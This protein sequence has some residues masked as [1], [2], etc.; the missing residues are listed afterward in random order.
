M[1]IRLKLILPAAAAFVIFAIILDAYWAPKLYNYAKE[2]FLEQMHS[3]LDAVKIDLIRHLL[4][5]D[6][7]ALY[8]SLEYQ[9]THHKNVWMNLRLYDHDHR[10]IFP[11]TDAP[12]DPLTDEGEPNRLQIPI[13]HDLVYNHRNIGEIHLLLD[14]TAHFKKR[15]QR[16]RELEQYLVLLLLGLFIVEY[17]WLNRQIRKP[18]ADLDKATE[19]LSQGDFTA[20]L[21]KFSRDELGRLSHHFDIMRKNLLSAQDKLKKKTGEAMA[22]SQA[23]SDFVAVMSHEIRTPMNGIVGMTQLLKETR[24]DDD[25]TEITELMDSACQSLL[26]IV[27]NILDISKVESGKMP[28]NPIEFNLEYLLHNAVKQVLLKADEKRVEVIMDYE[29]T[30]PK[31]LKG[32][33]GKIRQICLN[34]LSNAVKFTEQ[35]H[36]LLKVRCVKEQGGQKETKEQVDLTITVADTGVGIPQEQ[37]H[38]VFDAF[39]QADASS[40]RAYGGTGLG[41]AISKQLAKLMN[42]T[43][44]MESEPGKGTGFHFNLTLPKC[45]PP[46]DP[47]R[48]PIDAAGKRLLL[49]DAAPIDLDTLTVQLARLDADIVTLS[50][51]DLDIS[52]IL[53]Q[54]FHDCLFDLIIINGHMNFNDARQKI[55][56]IRQNQYSKNIPIMMLTPSAQRGDAEQLHQAG[57][58]AFLVKPVLPTL[59]HRAVCETLSRPIES[60]KSPLITAHTIREADQ[61]MTLS[62]TPLKL[63]GRLLLVEDNLVNQKVITKML[64]QTDLTVQVAKNGQV[65]VEMFCEQAFDLVLMDYQ[66]PVMDGIQATLKI[67]EFEHDNHRTK[68]PIMALTANVQPDVVQACYN[69]GMDAFIS[70]PVRFQVLTEK[71]KIFLNHF[72][73]T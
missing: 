62:D 73:A 46:P 66:M 63:S 55:N 72:E 27:N 21:P 68:T 31:A 19:K 38:S 42:G 11:L 56:T 70:K 22:A 10:Q 17:F 49:V 61:Q 6:F 23:K 4:A 69:A 26:S 20:P 5:N 8:A 28:L 34:L 16:I 24:L 33:A 57:I 45:Y 3:E 51:P 54:Q 37:Q 12:P 7:S 50:G 60:E 9:K 40:T 18:L 25:Q 13:K 35:G 67:R 29:V 44:T 52:Q 36:V 15:Q 39:V 47:I 59:L 41:L 14:W 43:L 32:D 2:D 48:V 53:D 58:Q 1:G 71:I 65:G 64:K 30:C